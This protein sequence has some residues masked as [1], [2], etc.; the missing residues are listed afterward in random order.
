MRLRY[1]P[2]SR[3]DIAEIYAHIAQHKPKASKAVIRRIRAVARELA[4]YPGLG[5]N[6]HIAGVRSF[7]AA[8]YP[9]V[10]YYTASNKELGIL[11]VRH[12]AR[13]APTEKDF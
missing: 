1:T 7:P 13:A 9:Y 6:T 3:A 8:P 11:H 2:R 12:G 5:R 10:V 4:Q